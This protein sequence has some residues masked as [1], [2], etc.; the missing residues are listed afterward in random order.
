M[1]EG[2]QDF[3]A[4]RL[5]RIL[6]SAFEQPDLDAFVCTLVLHSGFAHGEL[7]PWGHRIAGLS[8]ATK[9]PVPLRRPH[10]VAVAGVRLALG[11]APDR[12][13]GYAA[14]AGLELAREP[15]PPAACCRDDQR[16]LLGVCA[17]VGRVASELQPTVTRLLLARV[18]SA[19]P[20]QRLLDFWAES[21]ALG[22]PR[23]TEDL[24]T[25]AMRYLLTLPERHVALTESDRI[26][27]LWLST[28]LLDARWR[29]S[30]AEIEAL[31]GLI[32]DGRRGAVAALHQGY[33]PTALEAAMLLDALSGAPLGR[34]S[35]RGAIEGLLTVIDHFT[36]CANV[37]RN[38]QRSRPPLA[39]TDE[40]DVQ[41][42]FHALAI[43]VV[44]D[45]VQE[46]PAAK[47][48]GKASRLDFTSR[49]ARLGLEMKHVKDSAHAV[50]VRAEVL[51]DESTYHA[52][53]YVD[54]VIVFV[55]DP[56]RHIPPEDRPAFEGDLSQSVAIG[57]RTIQYITRV[58]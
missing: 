36:A 48:A 34:L 28:R 54:A 51:L 29:P 58:R 15:M 17:G 55:H 8:D 57:S 10:D 38:R 39:L 24:A 18:G 52:H 43:P 56:E 40:Y 41:D 9:S 13:P 3:T 46:D 12:F 31:D 26:A 35:R 25:R 42:L 21:L 23:L 37:L 50:R 2:N 30:D 32:R 49:S 11:E 19:S 33:R 44:P 16:L 22:A 14:A 4:A 7:S 53:P 5:Q 45:L 6:D 27:L 47:V 20:G 1:T